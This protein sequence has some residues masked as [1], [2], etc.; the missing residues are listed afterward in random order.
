MENKHL[1]YFKVE[2]FKRFDSLEVNDIG[3]FNLIVGDN[4][5]GKTSLLEAL[6]FDEKNY[7]QFLSNLYSALGINR[8]V[9]LKAIPGV[10]SFNYADV[11]NF[12]ELYFKKKGTPIS[13]DYSY[14]TG[15][16]EN[17]LLETFAKSELSIEQLDAMGNKNFIHQTSNYL[18]KIKS[19]NQES[20][21]YTT[22]FKEPNT[23][24]GYYPLTPFG[25]SY[26]DDLLEF[27]SEISQK[28]TDYN[29][30][31]K[32]LARFVPDIKSIE[33]NNAVIKNNSTLIIRENNAEEVM[34]IS[35]YGDGLNKF[36]RYILELFKCD[37]NRLM[38][39]EIDTGLHYS[40]MKENFKSLFRL[41][42]DNN[43]QIFA[44]THSKECLQYY[45]EALE[46]LGYQDKG[47]IIR[48]VEHKNKEVKAYTYIYEQFEHSI[49][50]DNEI[51]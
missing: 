37:G 48:L 26:Q 27:F 13:I 43:V 17:I 15:D 36:F 32:E 50:Y 9:F 45:K 46:D 49:D 40:K 30:I 10:D 41:A 51:R 11:F 39:D 47:R 33:I 25:L 22:F 5:V 24:K 7:N 23:Y 28:T 31:V 44:T 4:N 34:P 20:F 16:K 3:Q 6:L 2:N 21:L 42:L 19:K 18:I 1:T 12:V 8:K 38:I 29:I 35:F 14:N